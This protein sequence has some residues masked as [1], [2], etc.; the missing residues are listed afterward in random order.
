MKRNRN[1]NAEQ[2][3]LLSSRIYIVCLSLNIAILGFLIAYRQ[4]VFTKR[5][6]QPSLATF[7]LLEVLHPNTLTCPCQQVNIPYY[8]IFDI[9]SK[10]N[11]VSLTL[12]SLKSCSNLNEI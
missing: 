8:A 12:S 9:Q 5:V 10:V 7:E 11:Q 2:N 1:P 3:A 6:E 4:E